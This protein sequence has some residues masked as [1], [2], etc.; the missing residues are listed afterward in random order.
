VP[1]DV[2]VAGIDDPPAAAAAG[3]TT[4]FVPYHPLG[5]LAGTILAA[6][7][8][9]SAPASPEPLPTSLAIRATA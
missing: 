2:A 6:A 4:V 1:G 3:L 5:D 8:E 9:G 7:V